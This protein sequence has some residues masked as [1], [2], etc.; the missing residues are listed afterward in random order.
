[1]ILDV[2]RVGGISKQV[3]KQGKRQVCQVFKTSCH[4]DFNII[5]YVRHAYLLTCQLVIPLTKDS[6]NGLMFISSTFNL[7]LSFW[8]VFRIFHRLCSSPHFLFNI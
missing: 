1:M 4:S 6:A 7:Y 8:D 2:L 5:N 3:C